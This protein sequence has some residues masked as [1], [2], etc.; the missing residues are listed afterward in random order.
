LVEK[1]KGNNFYKEGKYP[2]AIECYTE[3][4]KRNPS[5]HT[6]YSNKAAAYM[7]LGEYPSAV[8]D[9]DKCLDINPNFIKAL[10]RKGKCYDIMKEYHLSFE[11][12]NKALKIDEQNQEATYGTQKALIMIQAL[13]QQESQQGR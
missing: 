5:D 7:A 12:Y 1:E 2:E 11:A 8:K 10:L 6:I 13:Q 4:A 3:A 9:C